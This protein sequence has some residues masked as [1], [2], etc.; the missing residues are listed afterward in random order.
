[1]QTEETRRAR[2]LVL[3]HSNTG[4][5]KLMA[6]LVAEGAA[7]VPE[8]EVRVRG[9]AEAN[10]D[11]LVWCDGVAVGSPTCMG[12]ISWQMKRFWDETARPLWPKI[13]GKLGCA[14]SSSGG[15]AGGGDDCDA[16]RGNRRRRRHPGTD[17]HG[18][19]RA[20]GPA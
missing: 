15:L 4:N 3:Y 8:T 20:P 7:S 11:D 13:E 1:M 16:E 19:P 18:R 12:T 5:T 14:F 6:D 2:I 10:A 9:V 17:R